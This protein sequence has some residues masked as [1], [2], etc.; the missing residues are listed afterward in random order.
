MAI[1]YSTLYDAY[2]NPD[3]AGN[4]ML[5]GATSGT[6]TNAPAPKDVHA[7]LQVDAIVAFANLP[8][9]T[10]SPVAP[11]VDIWVHGILPS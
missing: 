3:N 2:K 1:D 5:G 8:S 10:S 9:P 7:T 11:F 6:T 4:I